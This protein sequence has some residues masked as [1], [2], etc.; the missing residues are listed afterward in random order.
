MSSKY[1]GYMLAK[2]GLISYIICTLNSTNKFDPV[3]MYSTHRF[4][5]FTDIFDVY[6]TVCF[7]FQSIL[8]LCFPHALDR[9]ATGI[10]GWRY[11]LSISDGMSV[12]G[13]KPD[14]E[15]SSR[16]WRNIG[17]SAVLS[18]NYLVQ[19]V[20]YKLSLSEALFYFKAWKWT[21]YKCKNAR[22]T[23]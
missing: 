21:G 19:N 11:G 17:G 5:D 10:G 20:V 12:D 16:A 4:F 15:V 1:K 8:L 13:M 7:Y 3:L 22:F 14:P 9:A 6:S 23:Y 2:P 18:V